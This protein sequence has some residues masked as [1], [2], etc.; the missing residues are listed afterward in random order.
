MLVAAVASIGLAAAAA[1]PATVRVKDI[2]FR[3]HVTRIAKGDRVTWRFLDGQYVRHNVHSTGRRRF[4]SSHD[5][6][7]GTYT[8]RFRKAG[9]YRYICTRHPG[10]KGRVVVSRSA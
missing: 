3:P 2:D 6:T 8:V 1:G 9:K 5:Q 10:M 4:Q 7:E